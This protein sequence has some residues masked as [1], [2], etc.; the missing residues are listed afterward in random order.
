MR[1][2][3]GPRRV[4]GHGG[5]IA[6]ASSE[7][8][9]LPKDGPAFVTLC[10]REGAATDLPLQA[11]HGLARCDGLGAPP[12]PRPGPGPMALR[13]PEG[14]GV[15]STPEIRPGIGEPVAAIA[16]GSGSRT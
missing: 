11:P 5:G 1:I 13:V 7:L 16:P 9:W 12:R 4:V 3:D 8:C 6:G 2:L 15:P 14:R 10:N